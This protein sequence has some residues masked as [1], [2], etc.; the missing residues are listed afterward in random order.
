MRGTIM[1]KSQYALI[2]VCSLVCLLMT[3]CK[4]SKNNN[5]VWEDNEV[6]GGYKSAVST[7]WN[8][9]P[10]AKEETN[11]GPAEE[12]FL[13]LNEEDLKKSAVIDG[14][15]PQPKA[16]PGQKGSGLPSVDGFLAPH[17]ELAAV[18]KKLYFNTD[19]HIL[20]GKD[21]LA[22]IEH[23]VGYL[24]SHPDI[25]VFIEGHCDK[26][27]GEAHNQALGAR[28]ANYIRSLL[29]QRGIK[30]ERVHTISYGKERPVDLGDTQQALAKNRRAEFKIHL[31]K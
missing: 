26:R 23:I 18:F 24:K 14:A 22:A 1:K 7:L 15:I 19:D 2:F 12:D 20:R 17:G 25:Y 6:K 5:S 3:G 9:Q 31:K 8:D 29:V 11:F 27:G 13:A 4:K 28:R 10:D 30:P 16:E 21:S